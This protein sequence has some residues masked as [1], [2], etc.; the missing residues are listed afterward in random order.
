MEVL[1]V[2]LVIGLVLSFA[3]PAFRAIRYDIQNS[4]AQNALEKLVEARRSFYQYNK[5]VDIQSCRT[6]S[7]AAN[8]SF[9]GADA[10]TYAALN[11]E[12]LSASRSEERR[13][14]KEC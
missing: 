4:R 9:V 13:V 14:G 1:F 6:D 8:C 2:L 5:G 7:D 10:Q 12:N 3:L 11:C